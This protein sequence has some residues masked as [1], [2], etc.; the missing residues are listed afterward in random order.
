[1][2]IRFL[3]L[4][5]V[6][7]A[8]LP[9]F[10]QRVGIE[11]VPDR[12]EVV[13]DGRSRVT[14]TARVQSGNAP[15][16]DGTVVRFA[17]T[18]G[19]LEADR[20]ATSGGVARVVLVAGDQPASARITANLEGPFTAVPSETLVVF[21]A[22]AEGT[23]GRS[24]AKPW[25]RLVGREFV[26]YALN[27]GGTTARLAGAFSRNGGSVMTAGDLMIA[28]DA[29]QID[30]DRA[31][32]RASGNVIA[33]RGRESRSFD[34]FVWDLSGGTGFGELPGGAL[35]RVTGRDLAMA[36]VDIVP[37]SP[38][39]IVDQG[40]AES[41]VVCKQIDI[42]Q[43]GLGRIQMRDATLY[44]GGQKLLS[45]PYHT[46]VANQRTL[47]REQLLGLGPA[48][49]TLDLPFHF[50][51]RPRGVGTLHLRRGARFGS[52]IYA[53]RPGWTLDLDQSF[54]TDGGRGSFQ[55]LNLTRP[56]RGM[57]LQH[58]QQFGSATDLSLFVDSPN[59]RDL[60]GTMQFGHVIGGVRF[61]GFASGTR[62]SFVAPT[63]G[64]RSTSGDVRT[65]W[66]LES[67]PRTLPGLSWIRYTV[68]TAVQEA[69]SF[70]GGSST[71][72]LRSRSAGSR[73][74]TRPFSMGNGVVLTQSVVL[75]QTWSDRVEL[76]GGTFQGT[77]SVSR[78]LGTVGNLQANYDYISSPNRVTLS[79]VANPR[80]RLGIAADA[81]LASGVMLNVYGAQGLDVKQSSL[82][83]GIGVPLG[84]SW[85]ARL[86]RSDTTIDGGAFRETE[87]AF[88]RTL[89]AQSVGIY[90]S[91][92][93][94]RIQ[95][96]L[97][98]GLRF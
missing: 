60:F 53:S 77:T 16:P 21:S 92:V 43:G 3:L 37:G 95:L 57:R 64:T 27:V 22:E 97:T 48:G 38:F 72:T 13:P 89:G 68:N 51:V 59:S 52:S 88:V 84:N 34:R 1:M 55:I 6:M 36:P 98:G 46:M 31:L 76:A 5:L 94:R 47:F 62:T 86:R 58:G 33:Y 2:K 54:D 42:E 79:T 78:P 45:V 7:F 87:Y 41:T 8:S 25:I 61:S 23:R 90:Y 83:A 11:L 80:H 28:G 10:G 18:A 39:E 74:I 30:L 44:V 24:G 26:G 63:T 32:V 17:T 12:S 35:V 69:R 70:G 50:D 56:E 73:L 9:V 71:G 85:E 14:I 67:F 91:T 15:V 82:S 29:I 40:V 19:R 49:V 96:D 66:M 75:G 81:T 93:A 65:Q 4:A 20:V